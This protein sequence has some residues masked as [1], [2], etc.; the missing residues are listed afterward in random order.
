[1][2]SMKTKAAMAALCAA[3]LAMSVSAAN[4]ARSGDENDTSW[5]YS[6]PTAIVHPAAKSQGGGSL[7]PVRFG[8]ENDTSWLYNPPASRGAASR[9]SSVG[10]GSQPRQTVR[11]G[12]E[13]DHSW[14]AR[15]VN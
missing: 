5:L 6:P 8:D 9:G 14:L 1:M 12:D 4:A 13:N 10:D 15:P 11:F 2:K 7:P 3:G